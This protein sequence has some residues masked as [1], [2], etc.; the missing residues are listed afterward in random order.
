MQHYLAVVVYLALLSTYL[1]T[2]RKGT[3]WME[4][5][6]GWFTTSIN[7]KP[8]PVTRN[9]PS[10]TKKNTTASKALRAKSIIP[11]H[12][13]YECFLESHKAEDTALRVLDL[14]CNCTARTAECTAGLQ[15]SLAV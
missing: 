11:P 12:Q 8:P 9:S 1:I 10:V 6:K 3:Y 7:G 2:F 4:T 14:I 15:V 5:L 13:P